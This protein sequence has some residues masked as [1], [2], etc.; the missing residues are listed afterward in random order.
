MKG[1]KPNNF[2]LE[3]NKTKSINP[4]YNFLKI[5]ISYSFRVILLFCLPPTLIKH[6]RSH[7][8]PPIHMCPTNQPS[9]SSPNK[10]ITNEFPWTDLPPFLRELGAFLITWCLHC[11]RSSYRPRFHPHSQR[12]HL[13]SLGKTLLSSPLSLKWANLSSQEEEDLFSN[14]DII[15]HINFIISVLIL[16][17][18]MPHTDTTSWLCKTQEEIR[19]QSK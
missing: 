2:S 5:P 16:S 11:T 3:N 7:F 6:P 1:R 10:A 19:I 17:Q 12:I 18:L 13:Q 8:G 4:V 15:I 14:W 9:F